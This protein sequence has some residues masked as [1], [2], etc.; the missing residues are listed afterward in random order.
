M[1]ILI[2]TNNVKF[3]AS[4]SQKVAFVMLFALLTFSS[5]LNAQTKIT[6]TG[7]KI[8]ATDVNSM[9][10]K[11]G[12]ERDDAFSIIAPNVEKISESAFYGCTDLTSITFPKIKS[13]GDFAFM[14][15][16]SLKKISLGTELT[17]P[18]KISLG[19]Y[20]FERVPSGKADLILGKNVL[21]APSIGKSVQ[22]LDI[23][24]W[25][26]KFWNSITLH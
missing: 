1:E 19:D 20:V 4:F 17:E 9:L 2:M 23:Y 8:R 5:S 12:L 11:Y 10:A 26:G 21:P 22:G 13:I 6:F 15:C 3:F 7:T 25:I 24:L 16:R 14:D 18:T